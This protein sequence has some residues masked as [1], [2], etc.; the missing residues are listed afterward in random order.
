M[1]RSTTALAI[2]VGMLAL[3]ILLAVILRYDL[4]RLILIA[5]VVCRVF[6]LLIMVQGFGAI[7]ALKQNQSRTSD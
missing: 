4:P 6:V 3:D 7:K 2:A 1:R 5:T